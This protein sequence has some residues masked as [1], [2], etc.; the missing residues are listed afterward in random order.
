MA[1]AIFLNIVIPPNSICPGAVYRNGQGTLFAD[2]FSV[3]FQGTL[4]ALCNDTHIDHGDY[5]LGFCANMKCI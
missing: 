1:F 5:L 3:L 2:F 4:D